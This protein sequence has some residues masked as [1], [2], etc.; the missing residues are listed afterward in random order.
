MNLQSL[1]SPFRFFGPQWAARHDHTQLQVTSPASQKIRPFKIKR[2]GVLI[3]FCSKKDC[4]A[5]SRGKGK[6]NILPGDK[7]NPETGST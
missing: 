1:E 7:R 5:K 3:V 2:Y 4:I 6:K